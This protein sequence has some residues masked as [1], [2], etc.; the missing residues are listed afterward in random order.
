M[1][2][3]AIMQPT[4][5]PWLGYFGMMKQ[6][7]V[8]V[9]LDNVQ[10]EKRSWQQRNRIKGPQGPHLLTIPVIS[11][12]RGNQHICDVEIE[13]NGEFQARFIETFRHFYKRAEHFAEASALIFPL[14]ACQDRLLADYTMRITME[15][16]RALDITPKIMR[17]SHLGSAGR[18]A[19]LLANICSE[20]GAQQ[21][22]S[23]P[24]SY[25][26]LSQSED[27]DRAGIA[28]LF[29]TYR[30]EAYP[31][32]HGEFVSHLSVA[33]ALFCLGI[34]ETGNLI[35]RSLSLTSAAE[36]AASVSDVTKLKA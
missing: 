16:A 20:V 4:F 12:G 30:I 8:F 27:F 34:Q 11:K 5:L 17:G 21:Y 9:F 15:I 13:S 2:T 3:A 33:D 28:I 35:R 24:G 26:Y 14:L 19:D 29:N 32:L 1:I 36:Y 22:V 31:Q 10:F 25:D 7:D 23:A 6:V 18:K